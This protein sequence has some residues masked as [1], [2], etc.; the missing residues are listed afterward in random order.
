M[1]STTSSQLIGIVKEKD[2]LQVKALL[3]IWI[4]W[5]KP[6]STPIVVGLEI[7]KN[8][9]LVNLDPMAFLELKT[10]GSC[11]FILSEALFDYDFQGHYCRQIK[12]ISL[13]FDIGN[14]QTVMATLTQLNHKTIIEPDPKAVKYL[15]QPKDKEPLSIRSNW[16]STTA[17]CAF[18][19]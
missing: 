11:E 2:Y 13:S 6:I 1:K 19:T 10:K 9:S 18:S 16:K 14:G 7:S 5:R 3:L 4:E 8:I 15:L 17:N 12:T